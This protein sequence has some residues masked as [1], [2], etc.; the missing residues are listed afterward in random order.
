MSV[1]IE[2]EDCGHRHT[3]PERSDDPDGGGT[4]CPACGAT[5][6]VVRRGD[7]RWHPDP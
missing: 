2:C 5:P 6:F 7:L 1:A 3:I 4:I